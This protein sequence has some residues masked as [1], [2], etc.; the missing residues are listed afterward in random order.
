MPLPDPLHDFDRRSATAL[1]ILLYH[2]VTDRVSHGIENFS[3]KHID[4]TTFRRQMAYVKNH[5][6]PMSIDDVVE[7]THSGREFPPRAVVVTFDDGFRNNYGV[8]APILDDLGVPATF[9]VCAGMINTDLMFWVDVIEDCIN[10]TEKPLL[11]LPLADG[12]AQSFVLDSAEAKIAAVQDIKNVC[13]QVSAEQK[14]RI[15]ADLVAEAGVVPSASHAANYQIMS[16]DELRS[17]ATNPLF[18][19]G[20]HSLYHDVLSAQPPERMQ[21]DIELTL[22]LLSHNLHLPIRHFSYPEG[23]PRHYTEA[24]IRHLKILV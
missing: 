2:G 18:T 7:H 10:L 19:I 12:V 14:N 8:A 13:K 4:H 21:N 24:A 11:T 17:M 3:D 16:W 5:C 9:Y 23:Q 20:G 22:R 15:L 1:T 6:A